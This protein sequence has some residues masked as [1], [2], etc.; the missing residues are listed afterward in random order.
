MNIH[1]WSWGITLVLVGV[2]M[3]GIAF[4]YISQ[5]TGIALV[6]AGVSYIAGI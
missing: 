1:K 6:V 5:I 4:P 2:A 3:L